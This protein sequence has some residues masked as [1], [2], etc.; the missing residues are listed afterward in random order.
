M[1]NLLKKVVDNQLEVKR[2]M[3]VHFNKYAQSHILKEINK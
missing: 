1:D 3:S 2:V